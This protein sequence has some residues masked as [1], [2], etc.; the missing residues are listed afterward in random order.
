MAAFRGV[1]AKKTLTVGIKFRP[2]HR[3]GHIPEEKS[4]FAFALKVND[5]TVI[6]NAI[7]E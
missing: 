3:Y 4:F 1:N 7:S 2:F 5:A 6:R